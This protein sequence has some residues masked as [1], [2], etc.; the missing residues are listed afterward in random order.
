MICVISAKRKRLADEII[1]DSAE[2]S[3]TEDN[4]EEK[5]A[6]AHAID[7][8]L[9][10]RSKTL[11]GS[12]GKKWLKVN[13][14]KL[15]CI[16]QVIWYG[17]TGGTVYTWTCSSSDCSTCEG[18]TSCSNY[19]LTTRSERTSSDDLPLIPSCKYGDTVTLEYQ[20]NESLGVYE[21]A[22]TGKQGEIRF[23]KWQTHHIQY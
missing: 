19:L 10:T 4:D 1:P 11:A 2:Q 12:D 9:G 7:L 16:H 13:L 23:S 22:I 8:D 21:F 20:F 14:A 15:Y 6:A 3:N 17:S 18:S 5:Y